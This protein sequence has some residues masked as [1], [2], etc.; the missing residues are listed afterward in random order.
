MNPPLRPIGS[1]VLVQLQAEPTHS[2]TGALIIPE[3]VLRPV[4]VGKVLSI[5]PH[6]KADVQ[7][8]DCVFFDV[9][10]FG[11]DPYEGQRMLPEEGLLAKLEPV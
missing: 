11:L 7:V 1:N 9:K 10:V 3:S 2:D 5:G 4:S 8:G 6:C